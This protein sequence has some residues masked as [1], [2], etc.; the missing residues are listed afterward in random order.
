M[1]LTIPGKI[2]STNNGVAIVLSHGRKTQVDLSFILDA[3]PGDWILYA[4]NRAVK[5]ISESDAKEIISLLE[6]NYHPV[7]TA[8]LPLKFKKIIFKVRQGNN[9]LSK[10][11]ILYLLNLNGKDNLE[12]LCAEA[13]FLRKDKIKDFICIHGIIEFSN[14]CK[15]NCLYCGIRYEN[16]IERYRMTKDEIVEVATNA[17]KNEGYKLIVL[18]S[19]EDYSYSDNDLIDIIKYIK[20]KMR[21]FIFL[22]VGVRSKEFYKKAFEAGATGSLLRFETSNEL[23]FKKNK[24]DQDL[25]ERLDSIKDQIDIGYYMATGSLFGL[26]DQSLEEIADDLL[27]LQ[28]LN[29][30]MVSSGPYIEASGTPLAQVESEK[31]KV[32][33][34]KEKLELALKYIA[35]ARF[36]LP[37]AKIPV[38]T[39]LE[40]LDSEGRH[41]GLLAGANSLMFNLTPD[42]YCKK[43]KIYDNK[44]KDREKIW[45]K[46]GLFK[47]EESWEML[48]EKMNIN[49]QGE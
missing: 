26:P 16:K 20:R 30:P 39:A 18:Q 28:K 37:E 19:G 31:W 32:K 2:E 46:F 3:K 40:T 49:K 44:F 36:L 33:S 21:V 48:E 17:V 22:S 1:C 14:Y 8:R 12:T 34:N 11:E 38:T 35:I 47:D 9:K 15:N 41:K 29:P 13:N 24:P 5:K 42:K 45:Q 7:D 23:L 25:Q 27:A 10:N 43:Y 6:D 4:T